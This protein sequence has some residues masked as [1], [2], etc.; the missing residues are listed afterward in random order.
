MSNEF[1][2]FVGG[3]WCGILLRMATRY[4]IKLNEFRKGIALRRNSKE[5]DYSKELNRRFNDNYSSLIE[6]HSEYYNF[7]LSIKNVKYCLFSRRNGYSGIRIMRYSIVLR[8]FGKEIFTEN[9]STK[10]KP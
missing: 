6:W 9:R 7:W 3:F 4:F 5:R 8:L 1:L 10:I 2:Y